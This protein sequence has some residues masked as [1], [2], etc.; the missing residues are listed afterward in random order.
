MGS[1]KFWG[2]F[3][4]IALFVVFLGYRRSK[5]GYLIFVIVIGL[6]ALFA[7]KVLGFIQ[8]NAVA[9]NYKALTGSTLQIDVDP[10]GPVS[11]IFNKFSYSSDYSQITIILALT[12]IFFLGQFLKMIADFLKKTKPDESQRKR[13]K[14]VLKNFGLKS[15]SDIEKF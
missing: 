12:A 13:R 5:T 2:V 10:L 7:S 14:R 11:S 3:A 4:L 1:L 8:G 15:M 9:H 6:V